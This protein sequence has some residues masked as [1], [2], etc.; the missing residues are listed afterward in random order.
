MIEISR[1]DSE[2]L[3]LY[4]A[5]EGRYT[6]WED[7]KFDDPTCV[8]A[9]GEFRPGDD[10]SMPWLFWNDEIWYMVEGELELEWSSAPMFN[11]HHQAVIRPGDV[12]KVPLGTRVRIGVLGHK[13]GR[14]L[15][16][17]MPRPRHFGAEAFWEGKE[18]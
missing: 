6:T 9:F 1:F 4:R 10:L 7:V 11:D 8:V 3:K 17:T 16:V 5:Y 14:F 15:W 13:P 12:I 2:N 18:K